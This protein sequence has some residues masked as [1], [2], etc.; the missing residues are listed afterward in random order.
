MLVCAGDR[1]HGGPLLVVDDNED[2]TNSLGQML[3]M[4]GNKVRSRTM[5]WRQSR[6]PRSSSQG[7]PPRSRNAQTGRV[8][9]VPT[10]APAALGTEGGFDRLD[11]LGQD[12]IGIARTGRFRLPPC[13]TGRVQ[14]AH[15]SAGESRSRGLRSTANRRPPPSCSRGELKSLAIPAAVAALLLPSH[16]SASVHR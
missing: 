15:Q 7:D 9:Y 16:Q 6:P 13:Q 14:H 10:D 1:G 8:R 4:M 3:Q 11:R 12:E 5:V 2:G